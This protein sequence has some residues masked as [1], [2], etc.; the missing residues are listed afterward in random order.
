MTGIVASECNLSVEGRA[1]Q[2]LILTPRNPIA[3]FVFAH[4]A[5]AGMN[6]PFME[7]M[8]QS[9]WHRSVATLRYN[10]PYMQGGLKRP[11][12]EPLLFATVRAAVVRGGAI[13][14]DVPLFA[15]GKS[16]GGRMTSSAQSSEPL[17]SVRGIVFLGFPLHPPGKES[18]ERADHLKKVDVPMLFVQGTRDTLANLSLLQP[19]VNSLKG[20]ATLEVI[21]GADHS[22][23]VLR[24]SGKTDDEILEGIAAT[25]ADWCGGLA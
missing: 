21:D 15:G 9:L 14:P 20:I 13:L 1:V 10:F 8:S 12:P 16:M 18:T 3:L 25:I 6:H 19:V 11:D 22:F 7:Q 17:P 2:G 23:H 24:G 5:G 4:G